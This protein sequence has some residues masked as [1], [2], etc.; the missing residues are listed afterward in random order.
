MS[1]DLVQ[2]A[3]SAAGL[4][5]A[6]LAS[7]SGTSRPTL[8]AYERG[9]KSPTLATAERIIEAAG[10]ELTIQPRLDFTVEE[11]TR[12][13]VIHVPSHLPRQE[14]QHAFASVI[15]PLHLNWSGPARVFDLA[16]RRQRARVYEIV[17]REGTPA[18]IA[19]YID[20]ALLV[21]LW[22]DLVLPRAVRAAWAPLVGVA[23]Q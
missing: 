5:Q 23:G 19:R 18:D 15:L 9:Q 21:D 10:F 12:G 20:G 6:D 17:L 2:R 1:N 3:R 7:L 13:H 22:H 14:V 8:S 11:T 16:D 4:T